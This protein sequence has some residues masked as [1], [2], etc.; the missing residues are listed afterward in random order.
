[1][2][3]FITRIQVEADIAGLLPDD[4]EARLLINKYEDS[5]QSVEQIIIGIQ[6]SNV[7]ELSF[8]STLKEIDRNITREL[9]IVSKITPF[10]LLTFIRKNGQLTIAPLSPLGESPDNSEEREMFVTNLSKSPPGSEALIKS[11]LSAI[12]LIYSVPAQVDYYEVMEKLRE[13]LSVY[14]NLDVS[15]GG[16]LPIYEVA[17]KHI[18]TEL[19]LLVIVAAVLTSIIFFSNFMF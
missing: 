3:L 4:S 10:N 11:D 8:L 13:I 19:P 5:N 7:L 14:P 1:M 17:G 18:F 15:I 2:S 6:Y 9:P 16:W 12:S